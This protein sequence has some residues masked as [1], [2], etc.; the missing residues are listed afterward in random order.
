MEIKGKCINPK[1]TA[2]KIILINLSVFL[3]INVIK[4]YLYNNS[5]RKGI[6]NEL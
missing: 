3:K 1:I 2:L 4:I 6:K 5:S